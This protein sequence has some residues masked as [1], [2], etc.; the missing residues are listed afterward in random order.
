MYLRPAAAILS[1]VY[2]GVAEAS[3][4]SSG[5]TWTKSSQLVSKLRQDAGIHQ[6]IIAPLPVGSKRGNFRGPMRKRRG[7]KNVD[8]GM[9][10]QAR[11]CVPPAS[12][13]EQP[14]V[15]VLSAHVSGCPIDYSC[16]P[17]TESTKGGLCVPVESEMPLRYLEVT[18]SSTIKTRDF[19]E[20]IFYA[21][22]LE[23]ADCFAKVTTGCVAEQ[24]PECVD[25][26][27]FAYVGS[28]CEYYTCLREAYGDDLEVVKDSDSDTCWCKYYASVCYLCVETE[29]VT[30][31]FCEDAEEAC[32]LST[33]CKTTPAKTCFELHDP[34]EP[35]EEPV[36]TVAPNNAEDGFPGFVLDTAVA[37]RTGDTLAYTCDPAKEILLPQCDITDATECGKSA[38]CRWRPNHNKCVGICQERPEAK[39]SNECE[40]KEQ[41]CCA[42]KEQ[43]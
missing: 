20:C 14:D 1:L 8:S 7:R 22:A 3:S 24:P 17:S 27:D 9:T 2:K 38:D 40:W 37:S 21:H 11:E 28:Y 26:S 43:P 32:S 12:T 15:G 18:D 42:K 4:R 29:Y 6:S 41:G 35:T 34:D 16:V 10:K 36:P 13:N 23:E 33:C 31:D 30:G 5:N 19:C 39:C 25:E